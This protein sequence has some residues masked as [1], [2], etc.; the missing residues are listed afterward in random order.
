MSSSPDSTNLFPVTVE[1][2]SGLSVK[3]S[4]KETVGS[5][6]VSIYHGDSPERIQT[7]SP[8]AEVT[9]GGSVTLSGL[10]AGSPHFFKLV[11][12]GGAA[13]LVGERRPVVEGAPNLRD[14][15]GYEATDGRRVKWGRIFRSS[16]LGRLTDK[17]LA[18]IRQLGI[19]LVCDFRT[20]AEVR[21][22]PN[23]FPDSPAVDYVRLPIQH[24]EFEPTTVFERIKRGD[25]EWISED[26][27]LRGY[28]DSV[29]RYPHVWDRLFQLLANPQHRP[30]L[31]HCTGGKDRTGAAA[32]LILQALGVPEETVIADYGLS[33]GYNADMRRII[34]N[35]LQPF[36]VD[37][38]KVQPYFT[39]PE[40]R[41]RALLRH[42]DAR[43][44]SAVGYLVTRAGV[45]EQTIAQLKAD[46]LE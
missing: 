14:L 15:G 8:L 45:S 22:Q 46:L 33:D 30:L 18:Q 35:Y 6:G 16:N 9:E 31:F 17:G 27:M 34:Y 36:G 32:A 42:V 4:W 12:A 2:L 39:A 43:Y 37:L 13:A 19:K 3:I 10:D 21:K 25:Y 38:A 44:G 5:T 28:I 11:T 24:G 41:L 29:E 20:E 23:R 40:S 26:F 1:R 7:A